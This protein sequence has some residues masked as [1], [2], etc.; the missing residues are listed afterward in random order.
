[1]PGSHG[2]HHSTKPD[3]SSDSF[4][5][6]TAKNMDYRDGYIEGLKAGRDER[7]SKENDNAR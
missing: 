2:H 4:N 1:M 6:K 5:E 3:N 7:R